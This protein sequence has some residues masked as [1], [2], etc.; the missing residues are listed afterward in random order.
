MTLTKAFLFNQ[1][2]K[3]Q[4]GLNLRDKWRR[5]LDSVSI[6]NYCNEWG[7]F[8]MFQF[9][10]QRYGIKAKVLGRAWCPP[11]IDLFWFQLGQKNKILNMREIIAF[12]YV[13]EIMGGEREGGK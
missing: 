8:L 3:S 12:I 9:L 5:E 2:D 13:I 10:K 1:C 7:V 4:I 6:E 11:S